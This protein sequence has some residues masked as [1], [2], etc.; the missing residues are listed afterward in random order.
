[1]LCL[2][3]SLAR[4]SYFVPISNLLELI[5][6]ICLFHFLLKI[7]MVYCFSLRL[8]GW[9]VGHQFDLFRYLPMN[10]MFVTIGTEFSQFQSLRRR[11]S[12]LL[13]NISVNALI[14]IKTISVN[15]VFDTTGTFQNNRYSNIFSLVHE[16]P[17]DF[18]PQ[19]FFYIFF[20]NPS[21][22]FFSSTLLLYF[23]PKRRRR[24]AG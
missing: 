19:P 11:V 12:I 18:F 13:S 1:M 23:D 22:I 7:M 15:T 17:L 20:L 14:Y 21:S 6:R 5:N 2:V 8:E 3:Y 9:Y 4:K 24:K 10:C 16:P